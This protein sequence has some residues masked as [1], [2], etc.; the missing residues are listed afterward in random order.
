[1]PAPSPLNHRTF[2]VLS[3]ASAKL[4]AGAGVAALFLGAPTARA[5]DLSADWERVNGPRVV[6]YDGVDSPFFTPDGRLHTVQHLGRKQSTIRLNAASTGWETTGSPDVYV[7]PPPPRD[8]ERRLTTVGVWRRGQFYIGYSESGMAD[9]V[10]WR[11]N[12]KRQNTSGTGWEQVAAPWTDDFGSVGAWESIGKLSLMVGGPNETLY[13]VSY[14]TRSPRIARLD[15]ANNRW[16]TLTSPGDLDNR[17]RPVLAL[18]PSDGKPFFMASSGFV[19][20]R[21]DAETG[22]DNLPSVLPIDPVGSQTWRDRPIA[23]SLVFDGAGRLYV[24]YDNYRAIVGPPQGV[25]VRRNAADTGWEQVELPTGLA[26]RDGWNNDF[27]LER[28]PNGTIYAHNIGQRD[29]PKTVVRLN[30]A[31]TA[32]EAVGGSVGPTGFN[33]QL[34]FRPGDGRPYVV[35]DDKARSRIVMRLNDAGTAWEETGNGFSFGAM[36]DHSFVVGPDNRPWLAYQDANKGNRPTVVRMNAAGTDWEPVAGGWLTD[37]EATAPAFVFSPGPD[38]TAYVAYES[39]VG[40]ESR[41]FIKRLGRSGWESVGGG[42]LESVQRFPSRPSDTGLVA[43]ALAFSPEGMLHVFEAQ[44]F[45]S[46][47]WRLNKD[48]MAWERL[49]LN[50]TYRQEVKG[51]GVSMRFF[52]SGQVQLIGAADSVVYSSSSRGKPSPSGT[53]M[54]STQSDS[55]FGADPPDRAKGRVDGNPYGSELNGVYKASTSS[56]GDRNKRMAYLQG[57]SAGMMIS[58][59]SLLTIGSASILPRRRRFQPSFFVSL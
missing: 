55:D 53:D 26:I 54:P 14:G 15:D 52:S 22:W 48:G 6:A 43:P 13:A 16:E 34:L 32:W 58:P 40:S 5:Q 39:M 20:R 29:V 28:S 30:A 41:L 31:G 11:M 1:M 35:G 37:S 21:N 27:R 42:S 7:A 51:A 25:I 2:P 44:K 19:Y 10:A 24:A 38:R 50:W 57:N 23:R 3:A 8:T 36:N 33:G 45:V 17:D 9:G 4:L 47:L 18:R 59:V 46:N 12:V 56:N 49:P